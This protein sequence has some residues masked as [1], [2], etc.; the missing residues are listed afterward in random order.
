MPETYYDILGVDRNAEQAAIRKAYLKLSLKHH[1]DKNPDNQEAAKAKFIQIGTAYETLSDP[2]KRAA[3][4]RALEFGGMPSF[5]GGAAA[6]A[7]GAAAAAGASF[8][9]SAAYEK[10]SDFFDS[11]VAGMSESELATAMAGATLVGSLVGSVV[12]SRMLGGKKGGSGL[13]GA[14]GSMVGSMVASEMAGASVKALHNKSIERIQYKE[15]CRRA[16]ERGDPMPDPPAK[17]QWDDILEKTMGVVKGVASA[18]M[19]GNNGN[20]GNNN[21]NNNNNKNINDNNNNGSSTAGGDT[22]RSQQQGNNTNGDGDGGA[23]LAG[24]LWKAAA[25]GVKHMAQAQ[26]NAGGQTNSNTNANTNNGYR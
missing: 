14:A 3:Y 11:T 7:A 16:V 24:N 22:S 13:L 26:A 15:A 8:A 12:G 4:D 18:A 25:A 23:G 5:G 6:G 17:S 19:E 9:D 10:F 21:N 2:S 20:N 1:P